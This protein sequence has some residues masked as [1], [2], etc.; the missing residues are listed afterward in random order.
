MSLLSKYLLDSSTW[1]VKFLKEDEIRNLAQN[2]L[3]HAVINQMSEQS[4]HVGDGK[5]IDPTL[6]KE[7]V[8]YRFKSNE[9]QLPNGET[10]HKR[11]STR[12]LSK[13]MFSEL[14]NHTLS[15]ASEMDMTIEFRGDEAERYYSGDNRWYL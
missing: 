1:F 2:A 7:F 15:M 12:K 10:I 3:F 6:M 13:K 8:V 4:N 11:V 9:I 14:M 5:Y